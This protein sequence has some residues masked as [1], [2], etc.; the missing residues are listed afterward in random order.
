MRGE[1]RGRKGEGGEK[2]KSEGEDRK[3]GW[4]DPTK[5][6]NKSTPIDPKHPSSL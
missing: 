2:E 3:G 1:K 6:R 5:F 4:K